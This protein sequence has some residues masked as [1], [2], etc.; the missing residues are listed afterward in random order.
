MDSSKDTTGTLNALEQLVEIQEYKNTMGLLSPLKHVSYSSPSMWSDFML[1]KC[2]ERKR[3][4][5]KFCY[6]GG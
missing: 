3:R 1:E 6:K 4:I 2:Q 5:A